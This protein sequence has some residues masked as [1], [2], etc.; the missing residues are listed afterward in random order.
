LVV[1]NEREVNT[2]ELVWAKTTLENALPSGFTHTSI[3]N[4]L[5]ATSVNPQ[6]SALPRNCLRHQS[7]KYFLE[8][9]KLRN[10]ILL[11]KGLVLS[12]SSFF[13]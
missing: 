5:F 1:D 2:E 3:V 11:K 9:E 6:E 7:L 4:S 8:I 12:K 10:E 13:S